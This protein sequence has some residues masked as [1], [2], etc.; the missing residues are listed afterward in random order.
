MTLADQACV[1][2]VARILAFRER[3]KRGRKGGV[4]A[5]A[6]DLVRSSHALWDLAEPVTE[7]GRLAG[8]RL[9]MRTVGA[10]DAA[11]TAEMRERASAV[12]ATM[13]T[14]DGLAKAVDRVHALLAH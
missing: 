8:Q 1:S 13:R 14:E 6:Q 11:K 7:A 3:L 10:P 9:N 2:P 5:R 12:G 4:A